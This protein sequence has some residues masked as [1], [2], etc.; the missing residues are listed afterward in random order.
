M[1]ERP[2]SITAVN[3]DTVI[4]MENGLLHGIKVVKKYVFNAKM[5]IILILKINV[6]NFQKI[7]PML[8]EME[9]VSNV[10]MDSYSIPL[11]IFVFLM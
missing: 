1:S 2:Q 6:K 8:K 11:L 7:V 9:L 4:Q 10:M 3:M 5:V